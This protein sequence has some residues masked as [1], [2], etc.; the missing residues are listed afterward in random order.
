MSKQ[1]KRDKNK[2]SLKN[3]GKILWFIIK[4][5]YFLIK[6]IIFLI[7]KTYSKSKELKEKKLRKINPVYEEFS[8]IK[9]LDGDYKKWLES[10]SKSENKI[11]IILGARGTGKTAFGIKLLENLSSKQENRCFAIGFL[12][13]EL[14]S[15]IKGVTDISQIE[16]D[17]FVLID[18]GGILF[19]SRESMSNANKLL[20]NLILIS[21]HKNISILFISQNS[22]NLEVNIL[23][24]ADFLIL[25]PSSL[26]Q[27]DF[28]RKIVKNI[29]SSVEKEFQE[30][31]SKKGLTYI[32]SNDFKGFIS[33]PLPSFWKESLS[34]SFK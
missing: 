32:Y 18:E 30:L 26:L 16:N 29:Y 21:R 25:K 12:E 7:K 22:S 34:K 1:V 24:Q 28:E 14:P 10:V 31:K 33:N 11:G 15:F 8:V 2:E 9:V 27:K 19:N 20:S 6:G 17:S 5:P 23:R 3:L 13:K 4:L